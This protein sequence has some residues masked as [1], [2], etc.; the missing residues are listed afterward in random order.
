RL[1]AGE[2]SSIDSIETVEIL[3]FCEVTRTLYDIIQRAS[4]ALQNLGHVRHREP[5]LL[6]D[7]ARNSPAC[8]QIERPL[9]ADIQ[10]SVY[11]HARGIG[12]CFDDFIGVFNFFFQCLAPKVSCS[13]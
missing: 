12:T 6:L 8:L 5:R 1:H 2:E 4:R 9:T 13:F 7:T 3:Y 11:Q 10:P